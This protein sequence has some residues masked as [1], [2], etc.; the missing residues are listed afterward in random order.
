MRLGA[1]EKTCDKIATIKM[2]YPDVKLYRLNIILGAWN[3]GRKTKTTKARKKKN[4]AL[5]K[6]TIHIRDN[7]IAM[8][9][10]IVNDYNLLKDHIGRKQYHK[11]I[12]LKTR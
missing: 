11:M 3:D 2:Q 1:S 8:K 4:I 10:K 12:F 5:K 6:E 9:K 7:I